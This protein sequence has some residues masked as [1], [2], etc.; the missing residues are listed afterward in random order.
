[1]KSSRIHHTKTRIVGQLTFTFLRILSVIHSL[2]WGQGQA[3]LHSHLQNRLHTVHEEASEIDRWP[4][5]K[6]TAEGADIFPSLL[7]CRW[8]RNLTF[9]PWASP[10]F[11]SAGGVGV[12][13]ATAWP[14]SE[15]RTA[16]LR[17]AFNSRAWHQRWRLQRC[18]RGFHE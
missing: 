4:W 9:G 6:N 1:M 16:G 3:G 17:K 18:P 7:R 14:T 12:L 10:A 15:S 8:G 11:P 2:Q 13:A 5:A